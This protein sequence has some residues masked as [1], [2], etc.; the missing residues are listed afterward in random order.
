MEKL[1]LAGK[2]VLVVGAGL[3]GVSAAKFLTS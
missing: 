3:S 2:Q 1:E